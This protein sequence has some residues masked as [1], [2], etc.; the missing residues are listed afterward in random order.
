ME[1]PRS[2]K[3]EEVYVPRGDFDALTSYNKEYTRK[4]KKAFFSDQ[5]LFVSIV[6]KGGEP[7][8]MIKHHAQ[9]IVSAPFEGDPTYKSRLLPASP[10]LLSI[11][12]FLFYSWLS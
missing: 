12:Y 2:F 5:Y 9:K 7:A 4:W 3:P 1:K 11:Q 6:A 10:L 8:K